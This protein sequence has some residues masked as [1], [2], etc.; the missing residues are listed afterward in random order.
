MPLKHIRVCEVCDKIR[1]AACATSCYLDLKKVNWL[2]NIQ[3]GAG[4][5]EGKL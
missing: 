4:T 5:F 1:W 2:E 3:E